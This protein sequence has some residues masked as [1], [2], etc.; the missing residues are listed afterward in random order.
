VEKIE[1]LRNTTFGRRVAE[2]EADVLSSY[3]VETEQWRRIFGGEVDVVLGAKGSGKSAAYFLLIA[4]ENDLFDRGIAITAAENPRGQP[5][6]A[7]LITDPPA[8][9]EQ[10]Q[11]LWKLYFL[12][13]IAD[14]LVDYDI[15]TP[16]A[17]HVLEVLRGAKLH[18]GRPSLGRRLQDVLL[19]VRRYSE[20]ESLSGGLQFD[21]SGLPLFTG[22][23]TFR[24]PSADQAQHGLISADQLFRDADAALAEKGLSVWI[25]LDRLDVAFAASPD[26]EANAL[27]ALFRVYADNLALAN[28]KLKIFLRDD[29]WQRITRPGF[30]EASHVTGQITLAW[31]RGALLN[32]LMRRALSN[33]AVTEFY[34]CDAGEVLSDFSE[35]EALFERIFP[36]QVELGSNRS[37]TWNWMIGHTQDG[38]TR[39]APRELI[40]L[41][42]A[43]RLR[44]I[45]SVEVGRGAPE[46]EYMI[47]GPSIK[48]ALEEVSKVRLEQTV[49]A[50][51]PELRARIQQLD[52][53][54]AEQTVESLATIWSVTPEQADEM[55]QRLVEIGFFEP[56]TS[57]LGKTY[58][59]PLL[60][61]GPLRLTQGR[62]RA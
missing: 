41:V 33:P 21:P 14:V 22:K 61:R 45:N 55:A 6:F 56:R 38:T 18:E 3:F 25:L 49:Y 8:T 52:S 51:Y 58:W 32:L 23:I 19:Y 7:G 50:E 31:D 2:D 28:V 5:A 59:V 27:R 16:D 42:E 1:L 13:L 44:E 29:I 12:T 37:K 10:F 11:N 9:E 47:S 53:A 48:S 24:E 26:L 15:H 40:H 4:R 57:R 35:Q 60:Y 62:A 17:D 20:P 39:T 54:K 34:E 43:A 36:E 30:R 46:G